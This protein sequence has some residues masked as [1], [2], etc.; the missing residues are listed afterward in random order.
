MKSCHV[1]INDVVNFAETCKQGSGSK[2]YDYIKEDGSVQIKRNVAHGEGCE[3][4]AMTCAAN[5]MEQIMNEE[6]DED[7][8][9][10]PAKRL[11]LEP[12]HFSI[13]I[14]HSSIAW[15]QALQALDDKCQL[16]YPY[17]TTAVVHNAPN[18]KVSVIPGMYLRVPGV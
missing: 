7:A 10:P 13:N 2:L 5:E 14:Q 16:M 18:K 6:N 8:V 12:S 4:S 11:R 9:A 15:E 17:P 1:R 3:N